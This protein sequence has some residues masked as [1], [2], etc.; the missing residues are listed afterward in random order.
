MLDDY[1]NDGNGCK[2][3]KNGD[4]CVKSK[5]KV[6]GFNFNHYELI[7]KN[8]EEELYSCQ[9]SELVYGDKKKNK[10]KPG[11]FLL[12]VLNN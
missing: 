6:S 5:H 7:D 12:I 4:K 9:P 8:H 3:D 11:N 2:N 1:C 10:P